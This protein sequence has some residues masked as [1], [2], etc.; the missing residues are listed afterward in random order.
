MIKLIDANQRLS[1]Q[2]HPDDALARQLEVGPRGKTE[3]WFLLGEGGELFQGTKPGVTKAQF[4]AALAAGELESLLQRFETSDG[5]F[6][7]LP[8]RTVHALGTGC[9]LY[10]IQQTCDVTFRVYDWGRLG[11]D[12]K[13]RQTHVSE[14]LQTIDFERPGGPV[15]A[16][17]RVHPQSGTVRDLCECPYFEVSERCGD[18]IVGGDRRACSAVICLDG[19]GV[20][21]TRAGSVLL[22]PMT[23]T[24]VPAEA[25]EWLAQAASESLRLLVSRPRF[26]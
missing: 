1:V 20:L 9:L 15:D 25:G 14:S 21:S 17:M 5:A 3:C 10:E 12:G 11:L 18:L 16:P 4:Q 13:P 22:R 8:A 23:T 2:V 6:Y 24:L 19:E 7:F 26:L